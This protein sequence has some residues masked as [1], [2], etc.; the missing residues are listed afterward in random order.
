MI[1]YLNKL[2]P[3]LF[4][5]QN[6]V[7]ATTQV[8]SVICRFLVMLW[9]TW[10]IGTPIVH[11]SY[12]FVWLLFFILVSTSVFRLQSWKYFVTVATILIA[13]SFVVKYLPSPR[14]QEAHQIFLGDG[15]A[16]VLK[17]FLPPKIYEAMDNEFNKRYPPGSWCSEKTY[18][19]WRYSGFSGVRTPWAF[20]ADGF[21]QDGKKWSREVDSV[22]ND[23]DHFRIGVLNSLDNSDSS[24]G[25][26]NLNYF[27]NELERNKIP[28]WVQYEIP[29]NFVQGTICHSGWVFKQIDKNIYQ[30]M[31]GDVERCQTIKREDVGKRLIGISGLKFSV[32][33]IKITPPP[34]LRYW[35][36]VSQLLTVIIL[37]AGIVTL[38]RVRVS[39]IKMVA[40][41]GAILW[42]AGP[43]LYGKLDVIIR[44]AGGDDGLTH[45]AYARLILMD[46][47]KWNFA[48]ALMGVEQVY[49]YMPGYRYFLALSAMLFGDSHFYVLLI[50]V[51]GLYAIWK[52]ARA[53]WDKMFALIV[54][55]FLFSLCAD[56]MWHLSLEKGYSEPLGYGLFLLALALVLNMGK[57][58]VYSREKLAWSAFLFVLAIFVR[59]NLALSAAL[60]LAGMGVR[61]VWLKNYSLA[62]ALAIGT[63]PGFLIPLHNYVYGHTW[64]LLTSA[65]MIP[66]NLLV[67]PSVWVKVFLSHD[68][69]AYAAVIEHL[70]KWLD[71]P[72]KKLLLYVFP[73][74]LV[75]LVYH[76]RL[77]NWSE[78][79]LVLVVAGLH[80]PLM[81]YH[82]AGRYAELA[83]FM[84]LV[85]SMYFFSQLLVSKSMHGNILARLRIK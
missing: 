85:S 83:W 44:M 55:V 42:L 17:Q 82:P 3:V 35:Q 84:T 52:L 39:T 4:A 40:I 23:G 45:H 58:D 38:F 43:S 18:G 25:D 75:F 57:N 24:D 79:V 16:I 41:G 26:P 54:T 47:S 12:F 66:E 73:S 37:F 62:I 13:G 29:E 74:S 56:N 33:R 64:V 72:G 15:R 53:L 68:A 60:V 81:M 46:L 1:A 34:S 22:N 76:R 59:P 61:F 30:D 2:T 77:V 49:Y 5:P 7:Y 71:N 63:I 69:S 65:S 32:L 36:G 20:S 67:H 21:W 50:E 11:L 31:M 28:F 9:A 78:I 19:C 80:I 51:L 6:G 8:H 48:S 70:H 14:I 10:I 27:W